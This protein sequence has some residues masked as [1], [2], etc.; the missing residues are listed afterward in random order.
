MKVLVDTS[1]WIE[2]YHP[3]GSASVKRALSDAL[4]HHDVALIA[5]VVAE[6]LTGAKDERAL[7]Q[8][9]DDLR[10]LPLLPLGWA[11]AE[12]AGRLGRSLARV[13]RGAPMVDLLVASAA[14][15]HGHEVWH[16][17]DEHYAVISS[18]GGPANRNLKG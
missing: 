6:L 12:A 14:Q 10:S 1:A 8:L 11:E 7:R 5:P 9:Q 18:S 15:K 16:F 13:G 3:R 2:F 17:G 4:E